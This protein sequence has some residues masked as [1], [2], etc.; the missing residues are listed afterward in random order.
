MV[1]GTEEEPAWWGQCS[2][3]RNSFSSSVL[4]F[5]FEK[6]NWTRL[7]VNTEDST[8]KSQHGWGMV[9]STSN[10]GQLVEEV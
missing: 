1:F 4:N 2:T 9:G 10:R 8:V 5:F 7:V 3:V 6:Q